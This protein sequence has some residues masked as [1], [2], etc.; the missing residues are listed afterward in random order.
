MKMK[1]EVLVVV[2]GMMSSINAISQSFEVK[3]GPI[4]ESS[5]ITP[6]SIGNQVIDNNYVNSV[7][8]G[9]YLRKGPGYEDVWVA[10]KKEKDD[11]GGSTYYGYWSEISKSPNRSGTIFYPGDFVYQGD[12]VDGKKTGKGKY[13]SVNG[14]VYEG[15][16]VDDKFSGKGKITWSDGAVYEGDFVDDIRTGKG[17]YTWSSGD[18]YEGDWVDGDQTG[19]GKYTWVNGDVYEGDWVDGKQTGKGK[20]TWSDGDVYEGDFVDDKFIGK[21]KK[22]GADGELYEEDLVDGG[23]EGIVSS[24][25]VTIGTQ[26]WMTK[27]LNVDKFRNGD[28]IPQ[29]KTDEEWENAGKNKQ[30]A[31]CYYDK[32]P[33]NGAKYGKLY[34]WYAVNDSRGL[35]PVGFHIP[36]DA[37]WTKLVNFLGSDAGTKMKSKS[38][39]ISFTIGGLK[40]CPNCVNWNDEYRR[41]VPCHTC[42]DERWV[43]N[44]GDVTNTSGFSGLPG[45]GR[46]LDG[47]RIAFIN[48]VVG[49][50]WT[51]TEYSTTNAWALALV[52]GDGKVIRSS[53][54]SKGRGYSVRCLRD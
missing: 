49:A 19:K 20:I 7:Y 36:T 26:V 6:F 8:E 17:K 13:T 53:D 42:Q 25:T 24:Q 33:A 16:F 47:S 34:N 32:D 9:W 41:K 3:E 10:D 30:P 50:W 38:G 37:E 44:S 15:D 31:W 35:S 52:H 14:S 4:P 46:K 28:P 54:N 21:E 1:K 12:F 45:G 23:F 27:N 2:L 39:W 43:S 40:I 29:A 51:S 11:Y 22:H 5:Y 48:L 18:V